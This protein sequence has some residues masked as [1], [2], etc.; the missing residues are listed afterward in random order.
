MGY[1]C[2]LHLF[3]NQI[4]YEKVV[5][6]LK[7]QIG[8]LES[9]CEEFL[10]LYTVGGLNKYSKPEVLKRVDEVTRS[11]HEISN[12]LDKS[13]KINAEYSQIKDY[14]EQQLFIG[15]LNGHSDFC[16]FFEYY[17]FKHCADFFPHIALGKGGLNRNFNLNYKTLT[18]SIISEIDEWKE[19]LCHDM[20]GVTNWLSKEEIELLYLDKENLI[21]EEKT[22]GE[23]IYKFLEIAYQNK[24]G[25]VVGIDMRE[26]LLEELPGNKLLSLEA[27]RN[28]NTEGM[29]FKR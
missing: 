25:F 18:Y 28:L 3:D 1:W 19:V 27:W 20:M 5:P 26:N 21:F 29:L 9:E 8:N 14:K 23:S 11:I 24:L 17:I 2:T 6:E 4:F 7:G 16:K 15:K 13:F 12:S 22:T 10:K